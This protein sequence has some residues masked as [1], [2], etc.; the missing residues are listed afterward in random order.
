MD[1][2]QIDEPGKAA[3]IHDEVAGMRVGQGD[4]QWL[5]A[6][7]QRV[8][9]LAHELEF[10]DDLGTGTGI[11]DGLVEKAPSP[12]L[13]DIERRTER[14]VLPRNRRAWRRQWQQMQA[15]QRIGHRVEFVRQARR[16]ALDEIDDQRSTGQSG[17][18][19]DHLV[20]LRG[21]TRRREMTKGF[22]LQM[23]SPCR[24]RIVFI[25]IGD[26][27]QPSVLQTNMT[28]C[29]AGRR[30]RLALADRSEEVSH[31]AAACLR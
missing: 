16:P 5:R 23:Q 13:H 14:I 29:R 25:G 20:E 10:F 7:R 15:R 12:L 3:A 6:M 17:P 18:R 9:P 21:A 30:Q 28:V 31:C 27:R 24:R 26:A 1:L 2:F 22:R 8:R 11:G 19:L 4:R